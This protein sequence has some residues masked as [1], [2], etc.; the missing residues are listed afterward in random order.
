VAG[1]G[2]GLPPDIVYNDVIQQR[3][4]GLRISI[5]SR[6]GNV[7]LGVLG[8]IYFVSAIAT[9][10]YYIF[11]SWG[12]MGFTDYI[13]QL[14]L[15][16]SAI[17]GLLFVAI[18]ANNLGLMPWRRGAAAKSRSSRDRQTASAGGS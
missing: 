1:G 7:V 3:E 8:A 12:A 11:T 17:G 2:W 5:G 15:I 9:L 6:V 18:A 10:A 16:A 4:L 14:A 13:L